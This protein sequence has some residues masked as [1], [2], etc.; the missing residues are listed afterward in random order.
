MKLAK[1]VSR[2]IPVVLS[3]VLA[4]SACGGGGGGGTPPPGGTTPPPGGTTPPPGGTTPPPT[5]QSPTITVTGPEA[6]FEGTVIELTIVASDPDGDELTFG[7]KD[8]DGAEV[9]FDSIFPDSENGAMLMRFIAPQADQDTPFVVTASVSDGELEAAESLGIKVQAPLGTGEKIVFRQVEGSGATIVSS[10]WVLG[11]GENQAVK[12]HEGTAGVSFTETALSPNGLWMAVRSNDAAAGNT[13]HLHIVS[14]A[15]GTASA[16]YLAGMDNAAVTA[17]GFQWLAD[18]SAVAFMADGRFA[19]VDEVFAITTPP[20]DAA[21]SLRRISGDLPG[22]GDFV[23]VG[24]VLS[25][26]VAPLGG[27]IVLRGDLERAGFT[28]IFVTNIDGERRRVSGPLLDGDNDGSPNATARFDAASWSYD[29]SLMAFKGDPQ[30]DNV[31]ALYVANPSEE[32]SAD[33]VSGELPGREV[34]LFAWS[35]V[36]NELAFTDTRTSIASLG[37]RVHWIDMLAEPVVSR[38]LA[39][40]EDAGSIEVAF[41]F[42]WS[43]DGDSVAFHGN[44]YFGKPDF[45]LFI[46]PILPDV[47]EEPVLAISGAAYGT[48][49][50]PTYAWSPDAKNLA[51]FHQLNTDTF[52]DAYSLDANTVTRVLGQD[53]AFNAASCSFATAKWSSTGSVLA[54]KCLIREFNGIVNVP[55]FVS[56]RA[57]SP[58]YETV[59]FDNYVAKDFLWAADGERLFL[60]GTSPF[61]P[62]QLFVAT[63]ATAGN[64]QCLHSPSAFQTIN[65][66]WLVDENGMRE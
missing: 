42:E 39:A 17:S 61:D 1:P 24:N 64:A 49:P 25:F 66:F 48:I 13:R 16:D 50:S 10:L 56:L 60:T 5:N 32:D 3:S 6:V 29:G 46:A 47:T 22:D 57:D 34:Q 7:L 43:P 19:D 11:T 62:C 28:E 20:Q 37:D 15:D 52:L 38:V 14:V 53:D 21:T 33:V 18:S 59:I 31:D 55:S 51:A 41:S 65:K 35:P 9:T 30:G 12:L 40:D 54:T 26:T 36:R 58:P 23:P 63:L 27:F 8:G 45:S 4:L 44:R 2:F